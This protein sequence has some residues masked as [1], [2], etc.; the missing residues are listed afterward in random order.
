MLA[1]LNQFIFPDVVPQLIIILPT[2]TVQAENAL[3]IS[4]QPTI[5]PRQQHHLSWSLQFSERPRKLI[6]ISRPEYN[7]F[8]QRPAA[9]RLVHVKAIVLPIDT[10][11]NDDVFF[12][13]VINIAEI[14]VLVNEKEKLFL[15]CYLTSM[16]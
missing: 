13:H 11:F 6:Y 7:L 14:V 9:D 12:I 4:Q 16:D 1:N 2:I 15:G 10:H 8:L 5:S 3:R